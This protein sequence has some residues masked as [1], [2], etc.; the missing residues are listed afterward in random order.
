MN[1]RG[2]IEAIER[3]IGLLCVAQVVFPQKSGFYRLAEIAARLERSKMMALHDPTGFAA[4]W[5]RDHG[6]YDESFELRE[7]EL[8]VNDVLGHDPQRCYFKIAASPDEWKRY[9]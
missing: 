6:F 2:Y 9:Q 7:V 1:A 8:K 3:R 5:L 4:E